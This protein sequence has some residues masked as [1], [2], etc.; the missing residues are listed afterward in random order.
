MK[1]ALSIIVL[2]SLFASSAFAS[3][4]YADGQLNSLKECKAS[5]GQER[6]IKGST[7]SQNKKKK[8]KNKPSVQD[9]V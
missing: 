7:E 6:T 3:S 2:V 1:K 8:G 9:N 5:M 4:S